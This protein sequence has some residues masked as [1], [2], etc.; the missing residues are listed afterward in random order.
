M[1]RTIRAALCATALATGSFT[2]SSA[3]AAVQYVDVFFH[4]RTFFQ[5]TGATMPF[6]ISPS[7]PFD[8]RFYLDDSAPGP[9]SSPRLYL[10][11]SNGSGNYIPLASSYALAGPDHALTYFQIVSDL[12]TGGQATLE[13]SPTD[14]RFTVSDGVNSAYCTGCLGFWQTYDGVQI[15]NVQASVPEPATWAMMIAGFGLAGAVLRRRRDTRVV[16]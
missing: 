1:K 9:Q 4:V 8:A 7:T 16:A 10:R 11:L 14:S 12:P 2:A 5:E 6:G 13:W 3:S 15:A